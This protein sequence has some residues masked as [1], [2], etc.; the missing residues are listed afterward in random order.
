MCGH[1]LFVLEKSFVIIECAP[2]YFQLKKTLIHFTRKVP[3]I[4]NIQKTFTNAPFGFW[5][6]KI[7]NYYYS[8]KFLS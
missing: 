5:Y 6:L 2:N 8:S 1:V 3:C 4:Q 7:F